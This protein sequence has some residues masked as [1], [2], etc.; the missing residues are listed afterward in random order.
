MRRGRVRSS[1]GVSARP[2]STAAIRIRLDLSTAWSAAV[3]PASTA[4]KNKA[5]AL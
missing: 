2:C 1:T 4:M 5:K 3:E